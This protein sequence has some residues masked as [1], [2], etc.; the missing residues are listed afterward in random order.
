MLLS[1][2][3][4]NYASF[5]DVKTL[6]MVAAK[7]VKEYE[8]A[9]V[10]QANRYKLLK[11]AVIYGANASGKSNLLKA[12]AKMKNLVI[13]SSK[14]IQK[15]EPL[16]TEPFMLNI[17]TVK[18]PSFFEVC[19]IIDQIKYRYGFEVDSSRFKSEWLFQ[20]K[21]IQEAPLFI[22][23]EDD[24]DV[25]D[26]FIG[27]SGLEDRT[28]DNALFLSVCAQ[29]NVKLAGKLLAW[30]YNLNVISGL[31]DRNYQRYSED[32]FLRGGTPRN[33]IMQFLEKADLG[34]RDMIIERQESKTD[35]A[36]AG[37][38]M[39][40]VSQ[41]QQT[42]ISTSHNIYSDDGD[43]IGSAGFVFDFQES[44][45]S[46]KYFRLSGPIIDTLS[47]GKVLFVDELDARL[48]P[49]LTVEIVRL[50]NSRETNPNN[51]QLIFAT[52]DT[53]LLSSNLFRRDQVWFTEKDHVEATDLYS[54]VEY[55]TKKGLVRK[56]ASFEKDYF[57]GRYG[58]IPL[59]G[60]FNQIWS[61]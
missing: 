8:D 15:D 13:N 34:I 31:H 7:P 18:A 1:F 47:S 14:N 28:R 23:D 49:V 44:E 16:G 60:D 19:F 48:H 24:I 12:I 29:F 59:L 39:K 20:C 58:A 6:S 53:N 25:D 52:H 36:T 35:G 40:P 33:S 17:E 51:A 5:K 22:R 10:F 30:F 37:E 50:F 42:S 2:S 4:G 3:C 43:V 26:K 56:D 45:G 55:K 11:S 61:G 21:K 32:M 27:A 41:L 38:L 9:N 54:L 57:R 46:K